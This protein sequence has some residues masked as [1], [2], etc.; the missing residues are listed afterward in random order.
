LA[1]R[2]VRSA[3]RTIDVSGD[4]TNNSGREVTQA[5]DAALAQGVTINGSSS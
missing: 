4:G 2:A 3:R 1:L 5:R